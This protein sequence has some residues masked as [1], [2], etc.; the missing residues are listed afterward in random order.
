[1]NPHQVVSTNNWR[2]WLVSSG[3][4]V[5][6]GATLVWGI[7]HSPTPN[8]PLALDV[9]VAWAPPEPPAPPAPA[10]EQ[11]PSPPPPQPT[12]AKVKPLAPTPAATPQ[13]SPPVVAPPLAPVQQTLAPDT[14]VAAAPTAPAPVAAPAT[15]VVNASPT[16]QSVKAAP[17]GP[18]TTPKPADTSRWQAQLESM[19]LSYKQYPMVARRMRQEGIVTVEAHFSPLGELTFCV[20]AISSGFK[21]LDEAAL[22][23]VRKTAEA[24]R[25]SHQPGRNAELRIP[26]AFELKES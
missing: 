26:I 2:D 15:S 5:M 10:I 1:M 4:H 11:A 9:S 12:P 13:T 25:T 16:T 6:L 7:S 3:F 8:T 24:V 17:P 14:A 23:L 18:S 21:S 22:A 20:V 19:L